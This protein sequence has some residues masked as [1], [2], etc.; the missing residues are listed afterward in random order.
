M[1]QR[2]LLEFGSKHIKRELIHLYK[3]GNRNNQSHN[4]RKEGT[5]MFDLKTDAHSMGTSA[6]SKKT[7]K[8]SLGTSAH[9]MG[10]SAHSMGTSAYCKGTSV[11]S[12]LFTPNQQQPLVVIVE[13]MAQQAVDC[14]GYEAMNLKISM[15]GVLVKKSGKAAQNR[16]KMWTGLGSQGMF[17]RDPDQKKQFFKLLQT[18]IQKLSNSTTTSTPHPPP[19]HTTPPHNT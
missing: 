1:E 14:M 18:K 15:I 3:G 11:R 9:S 10:T 16:T 8:F 13:R 2:S 7:D 4:L 17:Q 5:T 12:N 19:T 6:Y